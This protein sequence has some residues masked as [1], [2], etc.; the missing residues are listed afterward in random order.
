MKP[1][2]RPTPRAWNA[3]LPVVATLF[4]A[5]A[6]GPPARSQE[7]SKAEALMQS[8]AASMAKQ[9]GLNANQTTQITKI[10]ADALSKMKALS[11]NPPA[12]KMA[13]VQRMKTIGDNRQQSLS[14]M[15]TPDQMKKYKQINQEDTAMM[16]TEVMAHSLKLT[17]DQV[18]KIDKIN[19]DAIQKMEAAKGQPYKIKMAR[20]LRSA[21]Q[22]KDAELQKV[23]TPE[24]WTSYQ[25]MKEQPKQGGQT[26]S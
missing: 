13:V 20:T 21:Q 12:D 5:L 3:T 14:L 8:R 22:N 26:T 17:D 1:N 15:L 16:Q 24:Q 7:S 11:A 25:Q 2:R 9:L 6:A 19:L 18:D 10:N 4:L 23:L